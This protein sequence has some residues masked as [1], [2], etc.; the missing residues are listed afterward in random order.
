MEAMRQQ[1]YLERVTNPSQPDYPAFPWRI[2]WTSVVAA[3]GYMT[4]R[5]WRILSANARSHAEP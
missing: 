2:V 3:A 4:W 1:V 5:M